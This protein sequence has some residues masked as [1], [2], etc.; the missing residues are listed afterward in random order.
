MKE[1]GP[2]GRQQT[3]ILFWKND[4]S[5]NAWQKHLFSGLPDLG[6]RH[7]KRQSLA[8][9]CHTTVGLGSLAVLYVTGK[10]S[11]VYPVSR[12]QSADIL[13]SSPVTR[14]RITSGKWMAL[15]PVCLWVQIITSICFVRILSTFE[16]NEAWEVAGFERTPV[17]FENSVSNQRTYSV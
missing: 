7:S 17:Q 16:A 13:S 6:R 15:P 10:R 9:N 11:R 4:S 12:P 8:H 5:F 2:I 14:K 3:S 1:S